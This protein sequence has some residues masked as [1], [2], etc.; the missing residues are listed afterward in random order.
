MADDSATGAA[1]PSGRTKKHADTASASS[2]QARLGDVIDALGE[3]GY[4]VAIAILAVVAMV[5]AASP[6]VALLL[7]GGVAVI[8]AQYAAAAGRAPWTPRFLRAVA[9]DRRWVERAADDG[10]DDAGAT[11]R[12]VT[13]RATWLTQGWFSLVWGVATALLGVSLPLLSFA[14]ASVLPA[15]ILLAAIG[16]AIWIR[17]GWLLASAGALG[18]LLLVYAVRVVF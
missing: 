12:L 14:G 10:D 2:R 13:R 18:V 6:T 7:G 17:D 3:R 9:V 11:R 8:G 16:A 5:V 15:A 1:A 4:G